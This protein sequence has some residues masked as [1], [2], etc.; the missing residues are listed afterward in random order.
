VLLGVAIT[1]TVVSCCCCCCCCC[2]AG[3]CSSMFEPH[4]CILHCYATDVTLGQAAQPCICNV[5]GFD[6]AWRMCSRLLLCCKKSTLFLPKLCSARLDSTAR[7]CLPLQ[8]GGDSLRAFATFITPDLAMGRWTFYIIFGAVQLMLS[9]VGLTRV[10]LSAVACND[11][12]LSAVYCSGVCVHIVVAAC[13][14]SVR[15]S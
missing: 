13:H 9:M 1:Y 15:C 5:C 12:W 4:C 14:H 10:L 2:C 3:V 11:A 7:A 8:V 6:A